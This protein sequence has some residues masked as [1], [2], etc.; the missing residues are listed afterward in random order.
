MNYLF[1]FLFVLLL[2]F[3]AGWISYRKFSAKADSSLAAVEK[4]A[5]DVAAAVKK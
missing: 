1:A 2:G 5:A 4:A 3:G